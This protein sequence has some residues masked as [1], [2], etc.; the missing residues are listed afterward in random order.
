MV[1]CEA[2]LEGFKS[3]CST[4]GGYMWC[5]EGVVDASWGVIGAVVAHQNINEAKFGAYFCHAREF[6]A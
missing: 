2:V 1:A 4:R 5:G 6:S 3:A